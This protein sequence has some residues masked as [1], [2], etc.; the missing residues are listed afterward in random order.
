MIINPITNRFLMVAAALA[1][2]FL[3]S[4]FGAEVTV[5]LVAG[6]KVEA[7]SIEERQQLWKSPFGGWGMTV[8]PFALQVDDTPILKWSSGREKLMA[9]AGEAGSTETGALVEELVV[10]LTGRDD[11]VKIEDLTSFKFDRRASVSL[12]LAAGRHAIHPFGI[13]FT[14]AEDD[15]LASEDPRVHIDAN[16]RRVEVMCHPVVF[17]LFAG[18]RSV[19]GRLWVTCAS[20]SLLAGMQN[21]FTEFDRQSGDKEG[22]AAAAGYRRVTLYLPA[23]VGHKPYQVNGLNF[24][25]DLTG[26]VK[27][28]TPASGRPALPSKARLIQS[29]RDTGVPGEE[30]VTSEVIVQMPAAKAVSAPKTRPFGV[31][32][33]GAKDEF[34][35][36]CGVTSV[37]C[38]GEVRMSVGGGLAGKPLRERK[39]H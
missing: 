36:A 30:G 8:W 38:Q 10:D 7:V 26:Q 4:T 28:P 15:T 23:S 18:K 34:T 31:S 22:T 5:A 25:L 37:V 3:T 9:Q 39:G 32:W 27:L 6:P 35:I 16:A 29:R 33:V 13:E 2:V 17:K 24:E 12:E 19:A 11:R 20:T 1:A 14:V 21:V